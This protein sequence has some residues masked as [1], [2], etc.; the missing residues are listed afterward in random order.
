MKTFQQWLAEVFPSNLG[1]QQQ[2]VA[3]RANQQTAAMAGK[4]RHNAR[5]EIS[6]F[7]LIG[8]HAS[9]KVSNE[10]HRAANASGSAC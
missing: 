1:Y 9:A 8:P 5:A 2:D 6:R 10:P 3:Q 7:S 4:K